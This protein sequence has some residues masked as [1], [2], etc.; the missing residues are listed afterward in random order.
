M[1]ANTSAVVFPTVQAPFAE[2]LVALAEARPDVVV[3][4][5]D[6]ARWTDVRLFADRFPERFIQVGMA[7]QNLIGLAGGLAKTGHYPIAVTYGVFA[8]RRAYDQVAMCLATGQTRAL[9]VGFLPGV[10]SRFPA[11]HQ[12]TDDVA[13]MRAIPGMTILDPADATEIRQALPAAVALDGPVYM[14]ANRGSVP[15]VFEPAQHPFTIGEAQLVR[16]GDV[17]VIAT[18]LGTVWALEVA[19]VL[20]TRGIEMAVLHV[21][22]V[23]PL[24]AE[25]V[26]SFSVGREAIV[27]VENHSVIGGL[28]EA[29]ATA[30]AE[31]GVGIKLR[32]LGIQDRWGEY[33][34]PAH[35]RRALGLDAEAIVEAVSAL[36]RSRE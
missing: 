29:V 23:K 16:R 9:I 5:A 22:T 27:V 17:G 20:A 33:G 19:P 4:S 18:G 1:L 25:T 14:R 8:T 7:E 26:A 13:L 30:L 3:L 36:A 11:T 12:A 34:S 2:A 21:P 6:V 28:A 10:M 31:R 15:L 24:D 32:R 35:N